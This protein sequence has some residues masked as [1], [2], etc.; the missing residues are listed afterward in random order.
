MPKYSHGF[1]IAF[2][3]ISDQEDGDDVTPEMVT[4]AIKRRLKT[5]KDNLLDICHVFDTVEIEE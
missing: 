4:E 2:E 3:V 1:D 5:N